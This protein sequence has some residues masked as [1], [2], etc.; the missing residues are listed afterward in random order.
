MLICVKFSNKLKK[1]F[2]RP[3]WVNFPNFG[4]KK[5]FRGKFSFVM[6]N[7]KWDSSTMPKKI[8]DRIPRKHRRTGRKTEGWTEGRT[9]RPYFIGPLQQLL[10]S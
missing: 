8:N 1:L 7:F 4:G 6:H 9:D 10:A 2:F 3:F 5:D